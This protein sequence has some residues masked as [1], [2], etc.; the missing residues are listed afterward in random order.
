MTRHLIARPC[1]YRLF[2]GFSHISIKATATACPS[3]PR[4]YPTWGFVA[5]DTARKIEEECL[6]TYQAEDFY[7]VYM[8]EVFRSTYQVVSKL[9][10]GSRSTAWLCKDLKYKLAILSI[11]VLSLYLTTE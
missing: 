11:Q 5:I 7:P 6:D 4:K 10:F 8:G 3:S 1:T 2:S 9:G